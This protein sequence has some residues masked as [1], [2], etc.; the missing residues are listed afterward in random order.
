MTS[1]MYKYLSLFILSCH[2]IF[3]GASCAKPP[4]NRCMRPLRHLD[5]VYM[6]E[7]CFMPSLENIF[8]KNG[9]VGNKES[10]FRS[11][12]VHLNLSRR[13]GF[14]VGSLKIGGYPRPIFGSKER[15]IGGNLVNQHTFSIPVIRAGRQFIQILNET[16]SELNL[17]NTSGSASGIP[18]RPRKT[19]LRRDI[20]TGTNPFQMFGFMQ[21]FNENPSPFSIVSNLNLIQKYTE[22]EGGKKCDNNG[23]SGVDNTCS[24]RIVRAITLISIGVIFGC[25]SIPFGFRWG[26]WYLGLIG[27]GFAILCCL[28][29]LSLV[30][31]WRNL[32]GLN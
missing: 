5:V 32:F 25:L 26:R 8:I 2:V 21:L 27:Y 11:N 20:G 19:S 9:A 4:F 17:E 7:S 23:R 16:V 15:S 29:G 6:T 18:Y 3:F 30:V 14:S 28:Y 10:L 31:G 13:A 1:S 22:C 24:F 12:R